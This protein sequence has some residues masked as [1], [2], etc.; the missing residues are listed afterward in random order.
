MAEEKSKL[1]SLF[2]QGEFAVTCEIGPPKNAQGDGIRK[3]TEHLKPFVDAVNLT[4]N[5]TAIVRL[6]S[7]GAGVHVLAAGGEPIIQMTTRDRNRIALQSDLLGAYSLG[8]RN[9]LCLSGD[10]Q[11]FGNHQGA[12]NVYDLDSIQL[13]QTVKDMREA[14][15]FQSGEVIKQGEP[16]FFIGA[17]ANPFADPFE[18][19]VLRLEKKIR[20]GAQFIQT[21]CIFDME[22]FEAFMDLARKRGLHQQAYIMAGV[23][24]IKS[25]KVA[26]YMQKNVS[27][28]LVP[29]GIVERM[30]KAVDQPAEGV[31]LCIEQ[32]KHLRTIPGVRG[33]HI[34]AVAWEEIVPEIVKGAGLLPRP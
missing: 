25:A 33:V 21:Q 27:G 29:D 24:P 6:S 14:K 2:E 16:R 26:K 32:I 10:H 15:V 34:M 23:M 13:I 19:R 20:A 30:S 9:V 22:R 31:K 4:D 8:V 28:M 18:F 17:V 1:Q 5:Q 11:T 12:K 3:H 7:I